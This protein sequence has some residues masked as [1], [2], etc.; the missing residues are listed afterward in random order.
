MESYCLAGQ[1]SERMKL[2]EAGSGKELNK[3]LEEAITAKQEA[4][5]KI[6]QLEAKLQE[7]EGKQGHVCSF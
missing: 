6:A 5:A 4:E 3:K 7:F 2:E 1:I